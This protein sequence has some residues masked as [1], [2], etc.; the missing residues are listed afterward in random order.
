MPERRTIAEYRHNETIEA[1]RRINAGIELLHQQ[2]ERRLKATASLEAKV[3]A[4]LQYFIR[5][6]QS[7]RREKN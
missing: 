7:V 4:A 1:L 2:G 5:A 6:W 3:E